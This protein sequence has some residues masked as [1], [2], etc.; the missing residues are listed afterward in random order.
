VPV[1]SGGVC[2]GVPSEVGGCLGAGGRPRHPGVGGGAGAPPG[3]GHGPGGGGIGGGGGGGVGCVWGVGGGG[4]CG[5][6]GGVWRRA[7]WR[8]GGDVGGPVGVVC[9]GVV[10]GADQDEAVQGGG[11]AVDPVSP[12]VDIA[13]L[14]WD[15]AGGQGAPAVPEGYGAAHGAGDGAAG[16][17]HV[18]GLAVAAEDDG[19]DFGV[20]G[21]PADG[22]GG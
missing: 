21:H 10:W 20:A 22:A 7:G 8:G 18:Q 4:G 19:D 12:V 17:A 13:P 14:G 15:V 6:G 11:S 1:V 5:G 3:P 16:P 9:G 2:P